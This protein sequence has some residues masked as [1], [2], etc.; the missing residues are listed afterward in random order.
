MSQMREMAVAGARQEKAGSVAEANARSAAEQEETLSEAAAGG[1]RQL[2][3]T[4]SGASF[5]TRRP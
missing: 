5:P 2:E 3:A 4:G 1:V